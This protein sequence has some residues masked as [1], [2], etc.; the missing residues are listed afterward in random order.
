LVRGQKYRFINNSG[1]LHPFQIQSSAGGSAYNTG[2]ENNGANSGNIDFN[3]QHDAPTRLYYQCTSHG[4]MIGN[5]YITGGASWQTTDVNTSTTEEIFTLLNVGV[6]TDNALARLDVYKG[7][8]ATDV[9]IFSVRSKTGAFNIQCSDTDAANPEWRLR[10]YS[11]EDIVFSPGGTGSSAEK[12]RIASNGRVGIGTATPAQKLDVDGTIRFGTSNIS[13]GTHTFTASA[14][15]AVTADSTAVGN[16]TAIEYTIF[17]SNGS[18]IQSQKVLIM[19][20][21]TT[22]YSQEFAMMSNPNMIATFSA[23]VNSGNVRLRATPETG[24]S[25]S[26]TIKFSKLIIE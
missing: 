26:T 14:G 2:V 24:I 9:D 23:D 19:D 22:A 1:G 4:G 3:V 6:G 20:N 16:A 21:G 10:T 25:G 8:S 13:S 17:I 5:I 15:S 12:V 11:S 18:N 7:T